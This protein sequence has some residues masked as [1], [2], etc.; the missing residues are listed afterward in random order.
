MRC[1]AKPPLKQSRSWARECPAFVEGVGVRALL[2]ERRH[3]FS[4][5]T[6]SFFLV[7]WLNTPGSEVGTP[8]PVGPT[9]GRAQSERPRG[10]GSAEDS[11]LKQRPSIQGPLYWKRPEA[12]G[13]SEGHVIVR[14][15][16]PASNASGT[17]LD[18]W[19][20]VRPMP[21]RSGSTKNHE[22]HYVGEN[23]T[24]TRGRNSPQVSRPRMFEMACLS[25]V[26]GWFEKSWP[27]KWPPRA[28]L[29]CAKSQQ[30]RRK[31]MR[32]RGRKSAASLAVAPVSLLTQRPGPP[33]HLTPQQVKV[34]E[35]VISSVPAGWFQSEDVLLTQ[36][37][38]HVQTAHELGQLVDNFDLRGCDIKQLNRLLMM[39]ERETRALTHL[40]TK[41]R[42]TQQSRITA[43]SAGTST[44]CHTAGRRPWERD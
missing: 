38:H 8:Y 35:E 21:F 1:S 33:K 15:P 16:D 25:G 20:G 11:A 23:D 27:S 9:N 10:V 19:L 14:G 6:C 7:G 28:F 31:V 30:F 22:A 40:A 2:L 4:K 43:R 41:M 17:A 29:T 18:R 39:R 32:Q 34:W 12:T 13:G 24:G 37:C 36:Y 26:G 42:L 3:V 44:E 5:Q